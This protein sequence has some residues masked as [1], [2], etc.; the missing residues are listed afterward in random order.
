MARAVV[1]WVAAAMA[2][3]VTVAV[4]A[5]SVADLE[6]RMAP[7]AIEGLQGTGAVADAA[8]AVDAAVDAAGAVVVVDS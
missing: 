3:A 8:V 7:V 6:A 5:A 4:R 1:A 2:T